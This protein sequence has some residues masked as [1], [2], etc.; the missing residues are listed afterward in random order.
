MTLFNAFCECGSIYGYYLQ[1][2]DMVPQCTSHQVGRSERA[3]E[4][5][6]GNRGIPDFSRRWDSVYPWSIAL[7]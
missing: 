6:E 1:N 5:G 4:L 7:H 3:S 2:A